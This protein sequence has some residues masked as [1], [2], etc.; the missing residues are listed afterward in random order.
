MGTT[1][2]TV[3][4]AWSPGLGAPLY[5]G[6]D[7]S[8]ASGVPVYKKGCPAGGGVCLG[9]VAYEWGP[10]HVQMKTPAPRYRLCVVES[11][12]LGTGR[13]DAEMASQGHNGRMS[14]ICNTRWVKVA[15]GDF[16]FL[17]L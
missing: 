3:E 10:L 8:P 6:E 2:C 14:G 1:P 13:T 15:T 16:S 12:W 11:T 7:A 5:A 4:G 17:T 9:P